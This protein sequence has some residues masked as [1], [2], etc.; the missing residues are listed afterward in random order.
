ME[1]RYAALNFIAGMLVFHKF[2]VPKFHIVKST[3]N[4]KLKNFVFSNLENFSQWPVD[5]L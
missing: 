1:L 3:I 5:T 4:M 2:D